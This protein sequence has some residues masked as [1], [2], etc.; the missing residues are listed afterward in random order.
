MPANSPRRILGYNK[1]RMPVY[2]YRTTQRPAEYF[3]GHFPDGRIHWKPCT[4]TTKY[5]Q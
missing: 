2:E 4:I 5:V 1:A 3:A